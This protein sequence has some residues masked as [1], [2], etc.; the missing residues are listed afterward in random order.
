MEE[1]QDERGAVQGQGR[2]DTQQGTRQRTF[3]SVWGDRS[4]RKNWLISEHG[5]TQVRKEQI[6]AL[7]EKLVE[8]APCGFVRPV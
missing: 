1:E 6:E 2:A 3:S 7:S 5:E 8:A 4:G